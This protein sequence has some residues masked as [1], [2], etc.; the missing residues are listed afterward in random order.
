MPD[1]LFLWNPPLLAKIIVLSETV[2]SAREWG[3]PT[4]LDYAGDSPATLN[5]PIWLTTN[6]SAPA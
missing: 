5:G 4:Q 6:R 1:V 3:L 2:I